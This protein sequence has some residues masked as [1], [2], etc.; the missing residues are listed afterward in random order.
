MV[1]FYRDE[2]NSRYGTAA[3]GTVSGTG[4]SF[5]TPVVW[6]SANTAFISCSFDS[7]AGKILVAY[8]DVGNSNYGTSVVAT[9]DSSDNSISFGSE[10][11][12]L[13]ANG[14]HYETIF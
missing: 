11:N 7:N 14:G 1:V 6:N 5:G 12:V 13:T 10:V 2:D 4:I 8:K 3:A 9:V